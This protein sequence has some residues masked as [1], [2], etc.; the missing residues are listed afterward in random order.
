MKSIHGTAS[1]IDMPSKWEH[2]TGKS[3]YKGMTQIIPSNQFTELD[4][5][6][7]TRESL[8]VSEFEVF[9][10]AYTDWYGEKP[11]MQCLE[12]QFDDYLT[13]GVQP[14]YVRHYC[15]QFIKNRPECVNAAQAR[16]Q[17]SRF[18]ERLATGLIIVFVAG[19][20]LLS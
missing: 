20:L 2:S 3:V 14:F 6:I 15:R 1:V 10:R 18:A 16:D 7:L 17:R 12:K 19:A 9:R 8:D 5:L 13:S 4:T 11:A